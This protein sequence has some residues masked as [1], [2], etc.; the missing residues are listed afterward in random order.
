MHDRMY[1]VPG[2]LGRT[3]GQDEARKHDLLPDA[4][5]MA[6]AMRGK[7]EVMQVS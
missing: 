6:I 3:M 2:R 1:R 7:H 4:W 5:V